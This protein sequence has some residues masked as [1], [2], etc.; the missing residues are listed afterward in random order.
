MFLRATE[1][2]SQWDN[3]GR[4]CKLLQAKINHCQKPRRLLCFL[5]TTSWCLYVCT[6]PFPPHLPTY[7]NSSKPSSC[8]LGSG[9]LETASSKASLFWV[10]RFTPTRKKYV[11][12]FKQLCTSLEF[13]IKINQ[14]H[15]DALR[16]RI[17]LHGKSLGSA[18]QKKPLSQL[19]RKTTSWIKFEH[20]TRSVQ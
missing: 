6:C 4:F 13:Q 3:T 10:L 20:L 2:Q 19:M 16:Y 15:D 17:S 12:Y 9:E 7:A 14:K 11:F 18:Q 8:L 5:P 1:L